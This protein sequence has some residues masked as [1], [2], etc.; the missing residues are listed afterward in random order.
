[1]TVETRKITFIDVPAPKPP[2]LRQMNAWFNKN[3]KL[4]MKRARENCYR[5]TGKY[6]L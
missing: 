1:M 2:T 3:R 4:V 5:L 6:S